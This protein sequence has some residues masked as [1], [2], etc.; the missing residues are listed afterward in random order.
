MA[1]KVLTGLN[2][3]SELLSNGSAGSSGQVLTSAGVGAVPTWTTISGGGTVDW[4][5]PLL[6]RVNSTSEGGQ[7]NWARSSDNTGYWYM[8]VYG[9]TSTPDLRVI[10]NSTLRATFNAGGNFTV[11]GKTF[12]GTTS[13]A[14]TIVGNY[15][16]AVSG[17]A[18]TAT[19]TTNVYHGL[20]V[21][22]TVT[23][24]GVTPT[25][26]N[27]SNVTVTA[28]SS[29]SP[30]TFSY[31][32]ATTGSTGFVSGVGTVSTTGLALNTKSISV[33]GIAITTDGSTQFNIGGKAGMTAYFGTPANTVDMYVGDSGGYFR[34]NGSSRLGVTSSGTVGAS[35]VY[36]NTLSTSYRAVYV[37]SS[38]S[39]DTLG[40]VASSRKL[41]KNIEPLAYTAEQILSIEPMQYHYNAEPDTNPKKAGFIAEDVHDAGLHAYISYGE[42]G[43]P[44][45]INYEFY[46][47]ALQQV[48]RHQDAQIKDLLARVAALEAK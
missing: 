43:E 33:N 46:V 18:G 11:P 29:A 5:N 31:A 3:T 12:I 45:T 40:Y 35:G 37:T 28:V 26:Y 1:Y 6:T 39:P 19:L 7:I 44:E 41:K 13:P 10:E 36:S 38:T 32:N 25:G 2:L 8:D 16:T 4:T 42:D 15:I 34:Y 17:S 48:V 21:G 23:V 27:A 9:S 14:T 24:A 22:D 47:S 20:S 30:W